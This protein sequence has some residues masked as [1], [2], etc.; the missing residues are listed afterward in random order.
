M[1]QHTSL[2][3]RSY[4]RI[5]MTL[6]A[7]WPAVWCQ[8]YGWRTRFQLQVPRFLFLPMAPA[9]TYTLRALFPHP[10]ICL[11]S[12]CDIAVTLLV[13]QTICYR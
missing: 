11:C 1:G 13:G 10:H 7:C 5:S 12:G 6:T 9:V 8:T 3:G 2:A 4:L